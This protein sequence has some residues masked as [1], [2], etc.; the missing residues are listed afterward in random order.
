MSSWFPD[1]VFPPRHCPE[2]MTIGEG[3][4]VDGAVKS[5]AVPVTVCLTVRELEI[6]PLTE[7][8]TLSH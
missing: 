1:L 3:L 2:L 5:R 7:V 6:T 8:K 4:N